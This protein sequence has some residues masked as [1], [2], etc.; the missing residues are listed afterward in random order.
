MIKTPHGFVDILYTDRDMY[1]NTPIFTK[2]LFI[3]A[4]NHKEAIDISKAFRNDASKDLDNTIIGVATRSVK[5]TFNRKVGRKVALTKAL[6]QTHLSKKQR[7]E[8]WDSFFQ[9]CDY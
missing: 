7:R 8:V 2:V 5:D 9:H 1:D 3:N 4:E 6:S